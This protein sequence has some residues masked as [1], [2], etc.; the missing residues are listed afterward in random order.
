MQR[1]INRQPKSGRIAYHQRVG[2]HCPK[3]NFTAKNNAIVQSRCLRGSSSFP[4]RLEWSVWFAWLCRFVFFLF[5]YCVNGMWHRAHWVQE[6]KILGSECQTS[7]TCSKRAKKDTKKR[8]RR[9]L[10][11]FSELPSLPSAGSRPG[12]FHTS[13]GCEPRSLIRVSLGCSIIQKLWGRT[14]EL[15]LIRQ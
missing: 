1:R 13:L 4:S 15:R 5:F 7:G 8:Q 3:R 2:L 14:I 6:F 10:L 11:V 9:G 12:C